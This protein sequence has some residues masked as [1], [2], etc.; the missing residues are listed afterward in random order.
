MK[1]PRKPSLHEMIR[2][3]VEND[4]LTIQDRRVM[5]E[6]FGTDCRAPKRQRLKSK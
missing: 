4:P 2:R 6:K 1:A 3:S 5:W